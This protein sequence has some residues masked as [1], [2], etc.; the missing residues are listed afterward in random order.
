MT[1]RV[2]S[3]L[4]K[5]FSL[6]SPSVCWPPPVPA[7]C[8]STPA[9]LAYLSSRQAGLQNKQ[10]RYLL[11]FFVSAGV[12]TMMLALGGII[13]LLSISVG[14]AL[15]VIIPVD[16][17]RGAAGRVA[18]VR[19]Q[20]VPSDCRRCRYPCSHI[21]SSIRFHVWPVVRADCPARVGAAGGQHLR[22]VADGGEALSKLTVF[23]WFGMGF[24]RLPLLLLSF[25]SGAAQRWITRQFALR[26]RLINVVSGL[27]LSGYRDLRPGHE[28][29]FDRGL[30]VSQPLHDAARGDAPARQSRPSA[31]IHGSAPP[32]P[33]SRRRQ[34]HQAIC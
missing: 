20:S 31:D 32:N 16:P 34:K 11:G 17:G 26:A 7:C 22:P 9:F 28:L 5:P 19:H 21:P 12:L 8:R 25:L 1:F 15:S 23:F 3:K 2:W 33:A 24:G 14:R 6:P 18:A 29:G 10:G 13:T 27:L 4:W 30:L